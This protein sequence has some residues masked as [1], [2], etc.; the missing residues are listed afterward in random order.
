MAA[1]VLLIAPLALSAAAPQSPS[2]SPAA[3]PTPRDDDDRL[4]RVQERR[5][6]LERD[7]ARLRGEERSLLGEVERLDLE[8][9]VRAEELRETQLELQ[10]TNR[11]MDETQRR[12][13]ALEASIERARPVLAVLASVLPPTVV[14]PVHGIVQIGSNLGRAVVMRAI[15]ARRCSPCA[16]TLA[17]S[18]S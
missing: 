8:A 18:E 15:A 2:A 1:A 14:I 12:L 6:A 5:A 13:H 4:R 17:I 11:E 10:R 9:R 16:M 3:A 7:L